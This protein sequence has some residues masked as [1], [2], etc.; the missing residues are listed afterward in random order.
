MEDI[1][2]EY[3]ASDLLPPAVLRAL[4]HV[5]VAAKTDLGRVREN[6]ED[7]F[8]YYVP[9][10]ESVLASRGQVFI[11][12]DGMGGHAAGQ[13]ASELTV[14]TFIEVYLSHPAADVR[15]ALTGALYAANRHV[16]MVS[17]AVPARRGMGT[18][19]TGMVLLQDTAY[20]VQVGDSRA[21]RMRNG[22]L[23][24]ITEDHTYMNE[25]VR[26]GVLTPEQAALTR[27]V[28]VE[29]NTQCDV[30]EFAIQPGDVYFLCSD[31]ILNHVE[32][33]QIGEILSANGPAESAWKLVGQA[34]MGGGSDN[35]TALVVR[36][37]QLEK[38][39]TE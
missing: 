22:E 12:C 9:S 3:A 25:M 30:Y 19:F 15:E 28:G 8:E 39:D 13:I 10:D 2:A 6:N 33:E 18:T 38:F 26:M 20:V 35:A 7:K 37:D 32:N 17:Q 5:T 16:Y 23:T 21:Y 31:G 1:T 34:L 24:Q 36:V 4:A 27:A 29:E 14:K 11:V